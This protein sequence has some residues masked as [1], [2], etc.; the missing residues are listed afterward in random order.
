METDPK[1]LRDLEGID[2]LKDREFSKIRKEKENII[3]E[4]SREFIKDQTLNF[5]GQI[6]EIQTEAEQMLRLTETSDVVGL[7]KKTET[8]ENALTSMR[9]SIE[10]TFELC[11]TDTKKY[12]VGISSDIRIRVKEFMDIDIGEGSE[13]KEHIQK[14]KWWQIWKSDKHWTTTT[15]YKVAN[16]SDVVNNLYQYIRVA[17][18]QIAESL[19]LAIDIGEIRGKIK[20]VVLNA[21]QKADADFDENDILMPVESVLS[22]VTIPDFSVVDSEKYGKMVLSEFPSAQVRDE[23]ISRLELKQAQVLEKIAGV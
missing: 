21:F 4:R 8:A 1:F 22:K 14:A 23:E 2:R 15:F 7:K 6:N 3:A 17:D 12:I 10:Q 13:E 16:V 5:I 11:A 19:K 20:N 18:S 9:R